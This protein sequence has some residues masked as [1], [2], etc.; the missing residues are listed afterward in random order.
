MNDPDTNPA[1]ATGREP[2]PAGGNMFADRCTSCGHYWAHNSGARD[3]FAAITRICPTCIAKRLPILDGVQLR[4][5]P[6]VVCA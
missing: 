5:R 6:A 4:D 2:K 3:R 1:A